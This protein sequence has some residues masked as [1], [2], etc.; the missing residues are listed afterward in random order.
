MTPYW[1][2]TA[3]LNYAAEGTFKLLDNM[4]RCGAD[5]NDDEGLAT[6]LYC[7]LEMFLQLDLP[8]F[9]IHDMLAYAGYWVEFFPTA[10][11]ELR[12]FSSCVAHVTQLL[13]ACALESF[14]K[15]GP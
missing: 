12:R 13:D 5:A 6:Q 4:S 15:S 11:E 10:L 2:L 9:N 1:V 14:M 8:Y 7:S 3:K